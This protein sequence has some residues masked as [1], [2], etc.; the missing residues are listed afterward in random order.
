M[1]GITG[2]ISGE[3]LRRRLSIADSFA[4]NARMTAIQSARKQIRRNF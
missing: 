3:L 1:A 2:L 4:D